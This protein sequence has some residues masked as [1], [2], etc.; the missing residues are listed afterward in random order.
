MYKK[1]FTY[2]IRSNV[3]LTNTKC[4]DKNVLVTSGLSYLRVVAAHRTGDEN[5]PRF[6]SNF[7]LRSVSLLFD[8]YV[9]L[10]FRVTIKLG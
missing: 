7:Y 1:D 8:L 3:L 4:L 5:R 6:H 2:I 9:F 10:S